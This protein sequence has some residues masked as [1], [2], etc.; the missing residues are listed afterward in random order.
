VGRDPIK[1]I[2]RR[3]GVQTPVAGTNR[4][5]LDIWLALIGIAVGVA[6]FLLPK[7]PWV[8]VSGCVLI[9]GLL[10]HPAWNAPWI[11]RGKIRRLGAIAFLV[12]ICSGIGFVSWPVS[13]PTPPP[14]FS[15]EWHLTIETSIAGGARGLKN[16]D[17]Y[18]P[19]TI[20][21]IWIVYTG[22]YG[23]SASPSNMAI[24]LKITNLFKEPDHGY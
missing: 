22:S 14:S 15:D 6:L 9:F 12:A 11:E 2:Q 20:S 4:E 5:P 8:I 1:N 21:G 18:D 23:N 7:P 17:P 13:I 10:L 3:W 19:T 24:F 16:P